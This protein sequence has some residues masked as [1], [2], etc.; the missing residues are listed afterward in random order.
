MDFIV[1]TLASAW[2][3]EQQTHSEGSWLATNAIFEGRKPGLLQGPKTQAPAR[4]ISPSIRPSLNDGGARGRSRC[5]FC[6]TVEI[7]SICSNYVNLQQ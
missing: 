1:Y 4:A 2:E 7:M 5:D 6:Y 3:A